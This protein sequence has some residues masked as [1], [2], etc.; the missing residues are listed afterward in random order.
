MADAPQLEVTVTDL[1]MTK[2]PHYRVV[3]RPPG[4]LALLLAEGMTVSFYRYLYNS[5]GERWFWWERRAMADD[6]LR[7]LIQN[8]KIEIYVLYVDGVPAGFT[9]LDY[10]EYDKDRSVAISI[11]G[12]I[13]E[14][15]GKGYG[16]YLASW[17]VDGI[18][19]R[20]PERLSTSIT[21]FDHPRAAGLL[22]KVGFSAVNQRVEHIADPR[23]RGLIDPNAPLPQMHHDTVAPAG[24]HAVIT[25]L[26]F[27]R[28]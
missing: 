15:I 7:S 26:P 8:E 24:P 17:A 22:Q 6:D 16:L 10:T 2:P 28:D 5:V 13:P 11:L 19:R 1:A 27:R 9:E 23:T 25:P 18:W 4:K 20:E 21:S 14:Y 3:P 12:L